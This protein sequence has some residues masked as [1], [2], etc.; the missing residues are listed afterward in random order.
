MVTCLTLLTL[1][2]MVL[3]PDVLAQ[4]PQPRMDRFGDPLPAPAIA[5]LGTGRLR[6]ADRVW[7]F[8]FAPDGKT[9]ASGGDDGVR[10]WEIPTGKELRRFGRWAAVVAFSPDG[11][12]LATGGHDS[13]VHLW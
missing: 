2:L 13:Q 10:L 7:S 5:R 8:A 4:A 12:L 6:H 3:M 1:A 9:L 11:R